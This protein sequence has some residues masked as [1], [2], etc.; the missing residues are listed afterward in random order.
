MTEL[1]RYNAQREYDIYQTI[2]MAD[3]V[4]KKD[5]EFCVKYDPESR[6]KWFYDEYREAYL[7]MDALTQQ[8][9]EHDKW[10]LQMEIG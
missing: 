8:Q 3:E 10:Q 7:N 4:S 2:M 6:G 1:D 9:I 5:F